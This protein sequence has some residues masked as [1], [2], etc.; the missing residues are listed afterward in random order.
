MS[1]TCVSR[2]TLLT[3]LSAIRQYAKDPEW[4][5]DW[6]MLWELTFDLSV[7]GESAA[8][9]RRPKLIEL[10]ATP[11]EL[12]VAETNVA[13]KAPHT[14]AARLR[15]LSGELRTALR[16]AEGGAP[17]ALVWRPPREA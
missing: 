17:G 9:K 15:A 11:L 1:T 13:T 6:G 10:R 12:D 4:R 3:R 2:I 7:H 14:I 8:K 5:N 16:A